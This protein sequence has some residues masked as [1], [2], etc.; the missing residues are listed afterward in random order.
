MI[1]LSNGKDIAIIAALPQNKEE[2]EKYLT[3]LGISGI[4]VFESA[5]DSL[6][7]RGTPT[8]IL[9]N[10]DGEILNVWVGKLPIDK[11]AEVINQIMS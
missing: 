4:E 8:I 3:S 2:G 11:E 1:D 6:Q 10:A 9:T 5:L 7:V